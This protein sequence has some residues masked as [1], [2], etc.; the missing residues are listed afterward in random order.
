MV[1][2]YPLLFLVVFITS[3]NFSHRRKSPYKGFSTTD[4]ITYYKYCDMGANRQQAS[5]GD[6]TEAI[7]SY[8]KMNDSVFWSSLETGYP[9]S[10]FLSYNQ[11]AGGDTYE[12]QLLKTT[13]GD[14][15]EYIVPAD[16]VFTHILKLPLPL[17]LHK[18]DRMKV[19]VGIIAIMDSVH[20]TNLQKALREY[21]KNMDMQEQLTLL[22]YVTSHNI[23]GN[24]K[25]HNLYFIPLHKGTGPRVKQ[26]EMVSLAYKGSF[27]N[28]TVFDS[29]PA[30]APLQF[31][32]GDSSQVIQGLA[33][34]IKMMRGGGEAK[35]IIPSQLAFGNNGSSTGI[36]PPYTTVVYEVTLLKVKAL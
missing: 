36:V 19:H 11:I 21:K 33:I 28:G 30:S 4:N 2:K 5:K 1:K 10:V 31:R 26:G 15:L 12:R 24:F 27:L 7:I 14:S 16:S 13:R 29:V 25:R 9:Y 18:G 17:F 8:A 20:Y 35:I 3:C 6:I 34:A 22:R 32:Y 23:P